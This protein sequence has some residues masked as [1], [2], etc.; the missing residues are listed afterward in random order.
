MGRVTDG[1]TCV[2]EALAAL[3]ILASA[4]TFIADK[5][6]FSKQV[7]VRASLVTSDTKNLSLL[8]SNNGQIDVAIK[9]VSIEIPGYGFTNPVKLAIGGELL[10]RNTSKLLKSVP[11]FLN[12]SVIA[13]TEDKNSKLS[14]VETTDCNVK[15]RYVAAND[16]QSGEIPLQLKCYAA[17]IVEPEELKKMIDSLGN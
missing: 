2:S 4:G 7:D 1:V 15:I 6:Y 10:P 5:V 12:S 13:D 3:A 9:Q 16:E 8:M 14:S 17:S 11:S